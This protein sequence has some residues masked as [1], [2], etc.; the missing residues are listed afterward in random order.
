MSHTLQDLKKAVQ[1]GLDYW[2][3]KPE[4]TLIKTCPKTEIEQGKVMLRLINRIE[5]LESR[6]A[7]L[8]P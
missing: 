7:L 1:D 8:N 6:L 5:E 4:Y 2:A 3:S